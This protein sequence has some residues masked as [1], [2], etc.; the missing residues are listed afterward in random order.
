MKA[1]KILFLTIG[2]FGLLLTACNSD[3]NPSGEEGEKDPPVIENYYTVTWKNYD[4]SVLE[5]DTNVKEGT[6]PKYD[7]TTPTKPEDNNYTYTWS[8]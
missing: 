5:T 3:K 6:M 2:L 1:N 4:G 8:G 7:G